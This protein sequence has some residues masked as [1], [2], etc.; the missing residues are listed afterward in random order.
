[1]I[2]SGYISY[3]VNPA[4]IDAEAEGFSALTLDN[5]KRFLMELLDK[6]LLYVNYCDM[7]DEEFAITNADKEFTRSFYDSED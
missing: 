2:E 5:Q 6:N 1:M 3:K 4:E 7:E